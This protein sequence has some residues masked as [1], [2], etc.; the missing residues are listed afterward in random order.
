VH[1]LS[2]VS[3][4]LVLVQTHEGV[5]L[6]PLRH[7]LVSSPDP[8]SFYDRSNYPTVAGTP[9]SHYSDATE[10]V[11]PS[12]SST[13]PPPPKAAGIVLFQPEQSTSQ[14]RNLGA[15]VLI[16]QQTGS[17]QQA[18]H[19]WSASTGPATPYT[20]ANIQ[21]TTNNAQE[22][23]PGLVDVLAIISRSRLSPRERQVLS[24]NLVSDQRT[25][26]GLAGGNTVP[27]PPPYSG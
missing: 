2:R 5:V 7:C 8:P 4:S 24:D 9:M 12:T 27:S 22:G 6:S 3:S 18:L 25:P 1:S 17:Q 11:T 13:L 21:T 23:V 26:A 16:T 10:R 20:S 15:D 19:P 14:S